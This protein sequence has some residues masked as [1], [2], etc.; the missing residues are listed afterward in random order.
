MNSAMFVPMFMNGMSSSPQLNGSSTHFN[1]KEMVHSFQSIMQGIT[2]KLQAVEVEQD[3]NSDALHLQ[4]DVEADLIDLF[5]KMSSIDSFTSDEQ[6]TIVHSLMTSLEQLLN[7]TDDELIESIHSINEALLEHGLI[8][9]DGEWIEQTIVLLLEQI[10]QFVELRQSND[11]GRVDAPLK[12]QVDASFLNRQAHV[13]TKLL[14][15]YLTGDH[16]TTHSMTS[17][18]NQQLLENIQQLRQVLNE[19]ET[20]KLTQ[21]LNKLENHLKL[22]RN[23]T[24]TSTNLQQVVQRVMNDTFQLRSDNSKPV[25]QLS[26]QN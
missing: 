14:T 11:L 21:F 25:N 23:E 26:L 13:L 2:N 15:F 24:Y 10:N 8:E 18:N 1:N 6:E 4:E 5:E 3:I 7:R 16:Q 20:P 9:E 12:N 19:A 22:S 17:T